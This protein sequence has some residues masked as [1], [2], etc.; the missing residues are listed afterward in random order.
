MGRPVH[1][2]DGIYASLA[3]VTPAV[4]E[5][6]LVHHHI[7]NNRNKKPYSIGRYQ[8]CMKRGGWG[9]THQGIA[10][11][12]NG[13]LFDGQNRLRACVG[14]DTPFQTL[15]FFNVSEHAMV[16][17]D[18]GTKRSGSDRAK[19]SGVKTGKWDVS[20]ARWMAFGRSRHNPDP[21]Q[22]VEIVKAVQ[23]A[24][25]FI[26]EQFPSAEKGVTVAPVLGAIGRAIDVVDRQR[27]VEFCGVLRDFTSEGEGDS[28]AV[29][30]N[31]WLRSNTKEQGGGPQG[32]RY[33]KTSNAIRYFADRKPLAKLYAR[34][35]AEF[36]IP[37]NLRALV[38]P[39][40]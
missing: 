6:I 19:I 16:L 23:P 8:E 4:A 29:I 15:V 36:P 7:E 9:L 21:G 17:V 38:R 1:I 18:E 24:L 2:A 35:E 11:N 3:T 33:L 22:E 26:R 20:M 14:A 32:E 34:E 5:R 25:A 28:A 12:E 31:K 10:F 40:E 30:L 27:L 37:E 39:A 13:L